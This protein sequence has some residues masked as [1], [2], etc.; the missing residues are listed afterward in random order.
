M[1]F[2]IFCAEP[3]SSKED[4]WPLW[5]LRQV[6][7]NRA[8]RIDAER[9]AQPPR[10]W[11][12]V[13]TGL[14]VRFVCAQCNNGWMSKLENRVKP[15]V[16]RLLDNAGTKLTVQEQTALAAWS[17]KNAMVFEALRIE[18]PWFFSTGERSAFRESLSPPARTNVWIAKCVEQAGV[19]SWAW[20]L[21][22]TVEGSSSRME[23]YVTTMGFGALAIQV[24]GGKLPESI[25]LATTVTVEQALGP[26]DDAIVR[27]RPG[28]QQV[29]KWPPP[30]GLRGELGLEPLGERWGP[31][32]E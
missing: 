4:A 29:I 15:I 23:A 18:P 27:V 31:H 19:Y 3:A 6:G 25:P 5:L 11:R 9:G 17:V 21:S 28:P 14:T 32:S 16:L 7:T 26:W 12:V 1:R 20:N 13:G 10:I 30:I 2:C 24:L 8:A 22:G